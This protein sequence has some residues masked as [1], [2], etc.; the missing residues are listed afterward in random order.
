MFLAVWAA[1]EALGATAGRTLLRGSRRAAELTK[2]SA[3][4]LYPMLAVL[5]LVACVRGPRRWQPWAV[6]AAAGAL[7]L[8]VVNAGYLAHG[9]GTPLAGLHG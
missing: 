8:V 4:T 2:F 3:L 9:S 5:A 1:F 7:S 6:V